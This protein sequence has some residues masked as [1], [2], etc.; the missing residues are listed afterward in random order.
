LTEF[1]LTRLSLISLLQ[2]I[3]GDVG[4]KIIW[5][6]GDRRNNRFGDTSGPKG[7]IFGRNWSRWWMLK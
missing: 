3:S 2:A 6:I 5:W 1:N 4:V 7:K